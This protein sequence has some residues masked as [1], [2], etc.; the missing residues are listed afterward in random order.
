[1]NRRRL[2][3]GLAGTGAFALTGCLA[4]D[5]ASDG[6]ADGTDDGS[7][8]ATT[9]TRTPEDTD[10][11]YDGTDSPDHT[12]TPAGDTVTPTDTTT[13]PP[14]E[15]PEAR[16][17]TD[18]SLTVHSSGCGTLASEATI[19]FEDATVV[20]DGTID[21]SQACYTAELDEVTYDP[22]P[23]EL[24]VAVAAV[25]TAPDD[26]PCADCIAEIEYSTRVSFDGGLPGSVTVVHVHGQDRETVATED[27]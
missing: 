10:S 6:P 3:R 24:T 22:A 18:Q 4:D 25:R 21:G 16:S 17:V 12:E 13:D 8:S 26:Q 23:D 11:S 5:P 20:V 15:T 2:L 19:G 9:D 1:M 14:S 27:R 7:D